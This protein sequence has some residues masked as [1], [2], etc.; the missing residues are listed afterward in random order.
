[1]DLNNRIKS[2]E[3]KLNS[4]KKNALEVRDKIK[5]L[6]TSSTD[7]EKSD[8]EIYKKNYSKISE[9]L[10]STQS[11][12]TELYEKKY[13][14]IQLKTQKLNCHKNLMKLSDTCETTPTQLKL[15]MSK[16]AF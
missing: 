2:F 9:N 8:I 12:L 11:K 10:K 5:I 3:N 13:E 6:L 1:M 7:I 15:A 4:C 14:K 16:I